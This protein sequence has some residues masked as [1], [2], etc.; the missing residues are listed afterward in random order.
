[1]FVSPAIRKVHEGVA[2][3]HDMYALFNRHNQSPF[4]E[5]R[6]NGTRYVGEW[7][8]ISE[9]DHD[10]MFEIL[11]PLF[12]RGDMFAMREFLVAS[13]TSV[14]FALTI[15]DRTRWFHG[16][17]DLSNRPSWPSPRHRLAP[18]PGSSTRWMGSNTSARATGIVWLT[19]GA[20]SARTRRVWEKA[21]R[22]KPSSDS[23]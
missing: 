11:P 9:A 5:N 19:P 13:V 22:S 18:S 17:C 20:V 15:D 14:F 23:S 10:R 12:Y 21:S 8:E 16:Y 7:F 3:R 6:M 1:M 4:D 2:S